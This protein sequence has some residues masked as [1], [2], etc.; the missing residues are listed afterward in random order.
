M[1]RMDMS[2]SINNIGFMNHMTNAENKHN[3]DAVA[4]KL[5]A[6]VKAGAS[7]RSVA[8]WRRVF[9]QCGL[10]YYSASDND[11]DYVRERAESILFD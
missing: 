1:M 10:S 11:I 3:L 8:T 4:S 6:S 7:I 2:T 9:S 5:A